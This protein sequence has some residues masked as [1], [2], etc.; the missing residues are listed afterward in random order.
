MEERN[1][2]ILMITHVVILR[3]VIRARSLLYSAY[4]DTVGWHESVQVSYSSL[5]CV[6]AGLLYTDSAR[7]RRK[8]CTQTS[9][10][11]MKIEH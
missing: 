11:D 2:S 4:L 5:H 1:H 10:S 6:Q 7:S 3:K 8:S 9:W